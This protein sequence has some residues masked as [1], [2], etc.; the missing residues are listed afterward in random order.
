[1]GIDSETEISVDLQV[2]PTSLGMV[3]LY[4]VT[5]THEIPMDF[6]PDEA[7]EI[8]EEIKSAAQKARNVKV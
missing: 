8:A 2:G 4:L 6:A 1:M 5:N 7:D 3:R